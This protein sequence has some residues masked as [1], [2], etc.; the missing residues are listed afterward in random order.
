MNYQAIYDRLIERSRN[1]TINGYSERH[2]ILPRCLGG[3][4]E[5]AN[6]AVLTAEEHYL[7]HQL[8]VRLYPGDLGILSA[9]H[10]MTTTRHAG[11]SA[12]KLYGWLR[13]RMAVAQT[14]LKRPPSVGQKIAARLRGRTLPPEVIAKMK[15]SMKGKIRSAE[16]RK[17]MSAG[18][19]GIK[20]SP[21]AVAKN[22][23]ARRGSKQSS[24]TVAKRIA[25]CQ[26][27]YAVNP[28]PK[29]SDEAKAKMRASRLAYIAE[30]GHG[31]G[32]EADV[33]RA[34][35]KGKPRPLEV[36]AKMVATRAANKAAR[37]GQS[38]LFEGATA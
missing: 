32:V 36:V 1:R 2:H 14:G 38:S 17:R 7:A 33:R 23:A 12:N 9:A 22:A 27:R 31:F 4:D 13:R 3:G 34:P 25:S 10:V 29:H 30:H 24:E 8:L 15:I 37:L 16:T 35:P 26:A 6:I 11:R 18:Q 28:K 5:E 19:K 21:E 20:R